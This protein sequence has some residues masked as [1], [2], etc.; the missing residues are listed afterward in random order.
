MNTALALLAA[1]AGALLLFT[2][3]CASNRPFRTRFAPCDTTQTNAACAKAAI[4]VT[5]DYKLGFVE[6]DDQGWF[7]DRAQLGAVENMLKTEAGIG[8]TN[9]AAGIIIVLF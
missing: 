3:G 5:P 2:A 8:H 9:N 4:E 7:W 6:F 1:A